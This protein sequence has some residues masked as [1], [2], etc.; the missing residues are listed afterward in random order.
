MIPSTADIFKEFERINKKIADRR[1]DGK[2][3]NR[4]YNLSILEL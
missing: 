1:I 4:G 2:T 3:S